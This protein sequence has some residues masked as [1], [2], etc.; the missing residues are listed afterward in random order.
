[1]RGWRVTGAGRLG[2]EIDVDAQLRTLTES[3]LQGPWQVP[4]E[5]VRWAVHQGAERV[6]LVVP[7]RGLRLVCPGVRLDRR[8]LEALAAAVDGGRPELERHRS[9]GAV[10]SEEALPLLWLAARCDLEL[11]AP[12]DDGRGRRLE[13]RAG[14]T[15]RLLVTSPDLVPRVT[16]RRTRLEPRRAGPW[17]RSVARFSRVPVELDGRQLGGRFPSGLYTLPLAGGLEGE[18][19]VAAL[20]EVPELW[21][22][23]H[24]LVAARASVPGYPPFQAAIEMAGWVAPPASAAALREAV[25]PALPKVID[26]AAEL[27]VRLGERAGELEEPTR[28]RVTRL[29][30]EAGSLGLRRA[31]AESVRILRT[32]AGRLL[33][34]AEVRE[35]ARQGRARLAGDRDEA[36][37]P[38]GALVVDP[39]ERAALLRLVPGLAEAGPGTALPQRRATPA[40][41]RAPRAAAEALRRAW[42]PPLDEQRLESAERRFVEAVAAA[43]QD[44]PE[45]RFRAGPGPVPAVASRGRVVLP[46]ESTVVREAVRRVAADP[47]WLYPALLALLEEARPPE[48]LRASWLVR[49]GLGRS[50]PEKV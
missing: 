38:D 3:V 27:L 8:L 9:I 49:R 45:V 6:E 37:I 31:E 14:E 26:A 35:L 42:R 39:S 47:A 23:R 13:V 19:C 17:L 40:W 7:R 43:W 32:A 30:L 24:G 41:R 21:L 4:A 33:S 34:V 5:V 1:M 12:C 2:L 16:A 15:P 22:L 20:G 36:S 29:L 48:A 18:V 28:R 44:G 25:T 50:R 11:E 46:R 10:E